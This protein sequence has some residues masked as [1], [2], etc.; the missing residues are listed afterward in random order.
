[1]EPTPDA[2]EQEIIDAVLP[3]ESQGFL[4]DYF[5]NGLFG[6][7][8]KFTKGL[9]YSDYD[10]YL[11]TDEAEDEE[12]FHSLN[13][14]NT[15]FD[16][17][18]PP[19]RKVIQFEDLEAV[20]QPFIDGKGLAENDFKEVTIHVYPKIRR[21]LRFNICSLNYKIV[22]N[23]NGKRVVK[24]Y[25]MEHENDNPDKK[26]ILCICSFKLDGKKHKLEKI[27]Q[28][29]EQ[30]NEFKEFFNDHRIAYIIFCLKEESDILKEYEMFP[31]PIK[32]VNEKYDKVRLIFYLEP[33]GEDEKEVLNMYAFNDLGKNFYFHMNA[34]HVIYRADDML[35]SGDIIKN[36]IARKKKEKEEN[37]LNSAYN[38]SKDQ[39][40]KE[41]NEAFLTFFNFLKNLK[42]YKYVLYISFKFDICLRYDEE[43]NLCISYIDFSHIIGELRTK[44]YNMIK[45]C[46]EILK[47]DLVDLEE[48]HTIDINVDFSD[49][50][51]YRCS[52][53][54][55]DNED[56]YYCYKCK[57]KFCRDCVWRNYKMNRGKAKFI[58][59]KHNILYFKTRDLN[60]F[61]NI[62][63]HKLGKDLFSHCT[64]ESKL[65]THSA[66]CNGC[67]QGFDDSPRY[68]CL[69]CRP[70]KVHSDG[71]YDYCEYC[72]QDMMK[73]TPRGLKMQEEVVER[74][75]SEETRLL[76]NAKETYKHEN[77]NHVYLMIALQYN[78]NENPYYDF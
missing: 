69:N 52:K 29:L 66:T 76:Y 71:F 8:K 67:R 47:P 22:K 50:E 31:E 63:C 37:F 20:I 51:C 3:E 38:K 41:R 34:D 40:I 49:K 36:S 35:C 73:K 62:D 13:I 60:Q 4:V 1:M 53:Q 70:G 24:D 55:A 6:E 78:C 12:M 21:N 75:Y 44:E 33:P 23:E 57:I 46:A 30:F 43:F 18:T 7:E 68:L 58:D 15:K 2:K 48:I 11:S 27:L 64:D 65:V 16:P 77:D 45:R 26:D 32:T 72:V 59:S 54:I 10:I 61:K 74:L 17:E 25:K 42:Q 5:L 28:L 19:S 14:C 56:M 39:L 9:T